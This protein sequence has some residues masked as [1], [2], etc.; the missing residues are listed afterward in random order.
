MLATARAGAMIELNY[1]L[2]AVFLDLA[3]VHFSELFDNAAGYGHF[4]TTAAAGTVTV[5]MAGT[6]VY[7][8]P[9]AVA[10]HNLTTILADAGSDADTFIQ[11]SLAFTVTGMPAN[12]RYIIAQKSDG[13]FIILAWNEPQIQSTTLPVADIVPNGSLV[14]VTFTD[15][16]AS[17][18]LYD[19][20]F[21][22]TIQRTFSPVAPA[23]TIPSA[24]FT[25]VGS[26][27]ILLITPI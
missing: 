16:V 11:G 13:T 3:L 19:P 22:T 8:Y 4:A 2:D 21:S 18:R 23:T 15:P 9:A 7:P 20:V 6:L 12:G 10:L 27:Q 17:A 24:E 1:V 14:T 26:P 5:N 25:L